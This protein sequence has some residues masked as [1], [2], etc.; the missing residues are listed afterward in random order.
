MVS[1]PTAQWGMDLLP[2]YQMFQKSFLL[3]ETRS[4]LE[5]LLPNFASNGYSNSHAPHSKVSWHTET[6]TW[7]EKISQ[8]PFGD[9]TNYVEAK[10]SG[11]SSK[12]LP[13]Q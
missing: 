13:E 12:N 11:E 6:Q 2:L 7:L 5:L 8:T 9:L 3:A 4:S 1:A 10:K